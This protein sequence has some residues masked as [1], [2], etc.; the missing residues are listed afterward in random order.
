MRASRGS[1]PRVVRE[2]CLGVFLG[3]FTGWEW[4]GAAA[5]NSLSSTARKKT[6][7]FFIFSMWTK[8]LYL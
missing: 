1:R 3:L 5:R 2:S 7:D 4:G 8:K 6:D